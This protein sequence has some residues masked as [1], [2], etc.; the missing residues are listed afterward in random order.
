MT[1]PRTDGPS[2]PPEGDV[3]T[4]AEL[5]RLGRLVRLSLGFNGVLLLI[6]V[7]VLYAL[8]VFVV[9]EP[10][11]VD[12]MEVI[13]AKDDALDGDPRVEMRDFFD[14]MTDLLDR[15]ARKQ[16]TNPA[17]V[18]PTKDAIDSAVETRTMHSEA[19]QAVLQKFRE[20][21]DYYDLAWPTVIPER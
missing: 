20:G 8:L 18:L 7:G 15:A 12:G 19:S 17:D 4:R 10:A 6:N 9:A 11:T 14:R 5:A 3:P 21:F 2:A 16:G 13:D 1:E